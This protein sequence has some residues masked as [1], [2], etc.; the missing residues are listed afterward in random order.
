MGNLQRRHS[1]YSDSASS[2]IGSE[3]EVDFK[4]KWTDADGRPA[5]TFKKELYS[6]TA[7]DTSSR[8]IFTGLCP[9]RVAVIDHLECLR[10]FVVSSGKTLTVIRTDDEF[11]TSSAIHWAREHNVKFKVSIPFEHDTVK[12]V[13]RFKR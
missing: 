1:Q 3:F 5:P 9:N 7:V 6:F 10:L 4:G 2:P 11:R 8:Y 13:E 12:V